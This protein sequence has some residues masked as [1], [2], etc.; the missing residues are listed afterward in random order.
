METVIWY[1]NPLIC[2]VVSRVIPSTC[3]QHSY[4]CLGDGCCPAALNL[5]CNNSTGKCL[6]PLNSESCFPWP[7][8]RSLTRR[9]QRLVHSHRHFAFQYVCCISHQIPG[10][11]SLR[12]VLPRNSFDMGGTSTIKGQRGDVGLGFR[13]FAMD[14]GLFLR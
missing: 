11:H 9:F 5:T 3:R 12:L 7:N 13:V 4:M 14:I 1:V 10:I 2:P 8:T 6:A